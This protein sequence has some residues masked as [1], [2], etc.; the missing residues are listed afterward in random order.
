MSFR[1]SERMHGRIKR[2]MVLS[3]LSRTM[4]ILTAIRMFLAYREALGEDQ[5]EPEVAS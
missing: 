1:A 5:D 3:G 4:L 2:V